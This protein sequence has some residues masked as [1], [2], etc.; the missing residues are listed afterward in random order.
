M[1]QLTA[2]HK[3]WKAYIQGMTPGCNH[4]EFGRADA[5]PT[6]TKQP[7]APWTNPFVFF[8]S[9]TSSK[10]CRKDDAGL[11]QLKK[12]LKSG[13]TTPSFAYV[14][15]SPCDDGSAQPCVPGAAAGLAPADKFLKS[16]LTEIESSAAYKSGGLIAITFDEAPQS[17]P[18]ADSSSCCSEPT[19]PNVPAATAP[20][21][22]TPTT[23][24]PTPTDTTTT[25]TST[26]S[27]TPSTGTTAT[28]TDTTAI[29]TTPGTP[30]GGGEV[31][32]LLI[33]KWVKPDNP[34]PIDMFNHFSLL[35]GIEE[36]FGLKQLGYAGASGVLTWTSS[37]FTGKGP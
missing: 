19:F 14:A 5:G 23:P 26:D 10:N 32:L 21:S 7:Y 16:V 2:D 28:S 9:V 11:G 4:P 3:T 22:T 6:S 30:P 35:K 8:L 17:G 15:P 13:S 36:L 37:V 27:T 12:D 1:D 24:A 33:S 34:D 29:P 31:G 18:D 20:T 25:P